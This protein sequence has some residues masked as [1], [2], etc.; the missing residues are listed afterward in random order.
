MDRGGEPMLVRMTPT[1]YL[2]CQSC[3]LPALG[4]AAFP[5]ASDELTG[6]LVPPHGIRVVDHEPHS[7]VLRTPHSRFTS[8]SVEVGMV[9]DAL[10]SRD[11]RVVTRYPSL[12]MTDMY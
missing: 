5:V 7:S 2:G 4:E 6:N 10:P 8:T 1:Q 12:S 9:K 3:F 11:E